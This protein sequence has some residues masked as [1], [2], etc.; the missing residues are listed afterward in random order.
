MK[1][2]SKIIA[3]N[4][5]YSGDYLKEG[6]LGHEIINLYK[7][8][9]GN[10]YIYLL[11]SGKIDKKHSGRIECVL[12]VR[13]VG[14]HRIEIIG[15][16]IGLEEVYGKVDQ[17]QYILENDIR[18]A[19]VLLS[20]IFRDNKSYQEIC[21]TFK[22][23]RVVRP[24][25]PIYAQYSAG[26]DEENPVLIEVNQ[27][28]QS[29]RQFISEEHTHDYKVLSDIINNDE[30][31]GEEVEC[32]NVENNSEELAHNIFD[33]CRITHYELAYS[34]ALGYFLESDREFANSF[35]REVLKIDGDLSDDYKVYRELHHID[36]LIVDKSRAII[37]EN[38]IKSA[39]NGVY[40]DPQKTKKDSQLDRYIDK[41][42]KEG[43]T[44]G[45]EILPYL[46]APNY[47]DIKDIEKYNRSDIKYKKIFY[48]DLY[49][50]MIKYPAYEGN[51]NFKIFTDAIKRHTLNYD[52]K[53]YDDMRERFL[54][55]LTALSTT[56]RPR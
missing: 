41:A 6:N 49:Q 9:N 38:K 3:L 7:S 20:D 24:A 33:I 27:A 40:I 36:L 4:K 1:N 47:N 39:V 56:P 10:N 52:N 43:E 17:K 18:Y 32:V 12:L 23:D 8:D 46:L 50:L 44:K 5:M 2:E 26:V 35:L 19:G 48:S 42:S 13:G 15:K 16:A 14:G 53:L 37:V 45:R 31:W 51:P 28:R 22:A 34:N 11:S 55:R 25:K 29:P 30:L 54:D 21:I